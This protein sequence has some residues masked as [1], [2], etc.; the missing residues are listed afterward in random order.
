MS[1]IAHLGTLRQQLLD[2]L[3][4]ISRHADAVSQE[5]C[6]YR[7]VGDACAR[8]RGCRNQ[9]LTA[10]GRYCTGAQLSYSRP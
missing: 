9:Q 1:D 5:R 7:G 6:P 8:P 10:Q 4:E 3:R 2:T